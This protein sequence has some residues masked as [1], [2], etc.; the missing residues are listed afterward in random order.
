VLL[1]IAAGVAAWQTHGLA[2]TAFLL[3][4]IVVSLPALSI[5]AFA[6]LGLL[7]DALG[8]EVPEPSPGRRRRAAAARETGRRQRARRV[9]L[10]AVLALA[11][12]GVTWYALAPA[13][14]SYQLSILLILPL[15]AVVLIRLHRRLP[16]RVAWAL[17]IGLA[18]VGP[19][20]Y[21]LVGGSQWWGW[22]QLTVLPLVLLIGRG[23]RSGG[24]GERSAYRVPMDG[25]WGPP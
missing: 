8:P 1:T 9:G 24:A 25:P 5:F 18:P 10:V 11:A 16:R 13:A 20:G 22:G 6:A 7:F 19:L 2:R 12:A 15:L 3:V 4:A 17:A 21:L 23:A 14:G